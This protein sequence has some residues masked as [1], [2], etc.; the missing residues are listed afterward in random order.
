MVVVRK[1]I[2]TVWYSEG[3]AVSEWV[4]HNQGAESSVR[5]ATVFEPT[6]AATRNYLLRPLLQFL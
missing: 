3:K 1:D 6:L 5:V 2:C 4:L